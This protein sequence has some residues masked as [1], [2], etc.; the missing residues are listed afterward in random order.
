MY[1]PWI[2][3]SI[4]SA[5]EAIDI[6][7]AVTQ[8]LSSQWKVN[9]V[10]NMIWQEISVLFL[11]HSEMIRFLLREK[12]VTTQ[13]ILSEISLFV[14]NP[15]LLNRAMFLCPPGPFLCSYNFS[16]TVLITLLGDKS[17]QRCCLWTHKDYHGLK[18]FRVLT[19]ILNFPILL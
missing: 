12:N 9:G 14:K 13:E 2:W 15:L 5:S 6:T 11:P 4:H 8:A 18:V 19:R 3:G 7:Y 10:W 1:I 17:T 16:L